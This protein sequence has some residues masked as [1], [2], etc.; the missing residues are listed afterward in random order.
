MTQWSKVYGRVPPHDPTRVSRPPRRN[1]H[2]SFGL[3]TSASAETPD[4]SAWVATVRRGTRTTR[5]GGSPSAHPSRRRGRR[6]GA[7]V[8]SVVGRPFTRPRGGPRARRSRTGGTSDLSIRGGESQG[9]DPPAPESGTRRVGVCATSYKQT[10]TSVSPPSD[11]GTTLDHSPARRA[12][13]TSRA[14]VKTSSTTR[15]P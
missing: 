6:S 8:P 12:S 1:T 4:P 11:P 2:L 5:A 13:S 15:R 3:M 14:R 7:G 9:S 10:G